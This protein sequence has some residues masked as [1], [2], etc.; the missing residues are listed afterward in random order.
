[1]TIRHTVFALPIL[2]IALSAF[3]QAKPVPMPPSTALV[4]KDTKT[5]SDFQLALEKTKNLQLQLQSTV[6]NAN[7]QIA[8][9]NAK[10]DGLIA[11][12]NAKMN[13]VKAENGWKEDEVGWD[14]GQGKFVKL[15]P[16]PAA[17]VVEKK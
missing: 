16:K 15:P 6:D 13:A 3:G 2:A 11:D 1:M 8:E 17:P 5:F 4:A 7:K 10:R 12:V 9:M 14:D